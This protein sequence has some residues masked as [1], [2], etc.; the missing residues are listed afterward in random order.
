MA[1]CDVVS[2]DD[3]LQKYLIPAADWARFQEYRDTLIRAIDTQDWSLLR[4]SRGPRTNTS[5]TMFS[6]QMKTPKFML[7]IR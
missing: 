5:G 2:Y 1:R 4:E 7:R 6:P 3:K